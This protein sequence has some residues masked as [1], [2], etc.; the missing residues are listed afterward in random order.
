MKKS[1]QILC[2][3]CRVPLKGPASPKAEDKMACPQCGVSDSFVK[4]MEEVGSNLTE[5]RATKVKLTAA[6]LKKGGGI[7]V[8]AGPTRQYRFISEEV[9]TPV[10][11]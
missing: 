11:H 2:A 9:T 10:V 3:A 8:N 7:T 6:D 5:E 4:V 1:R